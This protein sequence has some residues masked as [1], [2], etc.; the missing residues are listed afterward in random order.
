MLQSIFFIAQTWLPAELRVVNIIF[1]QNMEHTVIFY[2]S[3]AFEKSP[4][5]ILLDLCYIIG[6]CSLEALL[7]VN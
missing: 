2:A 7:S 4:D 6:L 5:A 3:A 1:S